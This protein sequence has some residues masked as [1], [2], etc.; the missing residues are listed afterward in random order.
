M[1]ENATGLDRLR[2]ATANGQ[3]HPAVLAAV[4]ELHETKSDRRAPKKAAE[5]DQEKQGAGE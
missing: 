1:D 2:D 3:L 4:E 5:D